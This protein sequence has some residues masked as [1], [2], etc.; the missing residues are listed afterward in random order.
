MQRARRPLSVSPPPDG[1]TVLESQRGPLAA[2]PYFPARQ[3]DVEQLGDIARARIVPN[4]EP[5][6][7][8]RQ[9]WRP[10]G[11][12]K[13]DWGATYFAAPE[14]LLGSQMRPMLVIPQNDRRKGFVI[15]IASTSPATC[16][17]SYGS[18]AFSR[19]ELQPG[20]PWVEEG[21][22][23]SVDDIWFYSPTERQVVMAVESMPLEFRRDELWRPDR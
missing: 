9:I 13:V 11:V 21:S 18:S 20:A 1:E 3:A 23:V 8:L 17:F 2:R 15:G 16:Y 7:Y 19:W 4:L 22:E 5:V 10:G 12:H 6:Q 14:T